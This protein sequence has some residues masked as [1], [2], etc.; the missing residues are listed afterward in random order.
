MW[1]FTRILN[2]IAGK[3]WTQETVYRKR[4]NSAFVGTNLETDLRQ[5]GI[6]TLVIVGLTANH[7]FQLLLAWREIWDSRRMS[8]P[9]RL[10]LSL[11]QPL[12]VQLR[13]AEAVHSAVLSDLH[14][15]FATVVDTAEILNGATS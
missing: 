5:H 6:D 11:A 14:L 9:M 3:T 4:V 8:F 13:S 15:E 2:C 7:S 12:T 10:Q 1:D